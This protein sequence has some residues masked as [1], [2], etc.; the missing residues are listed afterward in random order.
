M[1]KF[2]RGR[3]QKRQLREKELLLH[4]QTP[5][6]FF[7]PL[8][9]HPPSFRLVSFLSR[10]FISSSFCSISSLI[11][12]DC[13]F[14][15]P[16]WS[17]RHSSFKEEHSCALWLQFSFGSLL[18]MSLSIFLLKMPSNVM[19]FE[20]RDAFKCQGDKNASFIS[21]PLYS[22]VKNGWRKKISVTGRHEQQN[23]EA[24]NSKK[25]K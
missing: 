22:F 9:R 12:K 10:V 6:S 14:S 15:R 13:R 24:Y 2:F 21:L 3:E 8:I 18:S 7:C 23:L 20:T 16:W 25:C 1:M 4:L 19:S 5:L 17:L 11:M